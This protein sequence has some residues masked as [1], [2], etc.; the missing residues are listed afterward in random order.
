MN[1]VLFFFAFS[2]LLL[3]VTVKIDKKFSC[4]TL[5]QNQN[6]RNLIKEKKKRITR[7]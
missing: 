3:F 2:Q 7:T 5:P 1:D 6:Y 4:I